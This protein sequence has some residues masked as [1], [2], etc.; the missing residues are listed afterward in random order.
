MGGLSRF[1]FVVRWLVLGVLIGVGIGLV[2][3][4]FNLLLRVFEDIVL[5]IIV[6]VPYP[7]PLGEGGSLSILLNHPRLY[8]IPMVTALGGLLCGVIVYNLAPE[9]G[10]SGTPEVVRSFSRGFRVRPVVV[11][12]K[13]LVSAITIG[14]GGSGGKEG[15]AAQYSA[16]LGSFITEL[17]GLSPEDR[18][19]AIAVGLGAGIGTI[20]KSPIGGVVF[21][22]ELLRR[23]GF[24]IKILYPA[25]IASLV[26]SVV[27]DLVFSFKPYLGLYRGSVSLFELPLFA[28][29]GM[30]TG[31]IGIL[32][33]KSFHWFSTVFSRL[34]VPRFL[35]P[36]VGG[37]LAGLVTLLAPE[38]LGTSVGWVDIM[39]FNKLS[40]LY[41]PVLPIIALIVLLPFLKI[42]ATSLT[43]GSGVV[44]ASSCQ[45]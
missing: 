1:S 42:M 36:M 45:P 32:F 33:S 44:L 2:S 7:H 14:F 30:A 5:G 17:L 40:L 21:A 12:V 23:R 28:V 35:K 18:R 43:V 8:L 11:P 19:V 31:F 37:F 41:S 34:G 22:V 13:V 20:L 3:V 9:A 6:G 16:G 39:M 26:G 27:F 25:L 38:V 29:L 15:P 24:S 4:A 10:G